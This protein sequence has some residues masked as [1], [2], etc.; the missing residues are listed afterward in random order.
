M[1]VFL[2][3]IKP[4]PMTL[5]P[6]MDSLDEVMALAQAR[7]PQVSRNEIVSLLLI[8]HNTLLKEI[9]KEQ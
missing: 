1:M 4:I 3:P 9:S 7:V 6:T 5:Y 2:L 8:Y